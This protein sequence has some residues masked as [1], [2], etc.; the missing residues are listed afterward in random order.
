MKPVDNP[1]AV[2][3]TNDVSKRTAAS[4]GQDMPVSKDVNVFRGESETQ[5]ATPAQYKS[6]DLVDDRKEPSHHDA[7]KLAISVLED[8]LEKVEER[9][10]EV[11]ETNSTLKT[12]IKALRTNTTSTTNQGGPTTGI[13]VTVIIALTFSLFT[14]SYR[15]LQDHKQLC[16]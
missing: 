6:S 1:R 15:Q 3:T 11:E 16:S 14:T 8:K 12:K 5:P 13:L 9:I 4:A 7:L 10:K 2:E